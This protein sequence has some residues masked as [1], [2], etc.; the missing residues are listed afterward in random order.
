MTRVN[1]DD[2]RWE[3]LFASGLQR[4]D[5]P[6]AAS[7]GRGDQRVRRFGARGCAVP[8]GARVRDHPRQTLS[9]CAGPANSPP[10][11]PAGL[12]PA[13]DLAACYGVTYQDGEHR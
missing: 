9:G 3:A 1:A 11:R 10:R 5:A 8:D 2:A 7:V 13:L 4:S 12:R 6:S